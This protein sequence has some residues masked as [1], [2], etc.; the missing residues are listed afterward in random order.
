MVKTHPTPFRDR[1][2]FGKVTDKKMKQ[3]NPKLVELILILS[4]EF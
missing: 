1:F 3:I 2:D 4:N